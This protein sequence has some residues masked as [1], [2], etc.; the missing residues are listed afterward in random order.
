M[1]EK[2][3]ENQTVICPVGS[4]FMDLDK[5]FGKETEFF[6]HLTRSRIEFLKAIKSLIDEKI[7]SLEKKETKKGK[8][9]MTKIKVQ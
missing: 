7:D 3:N 9:K 6:E 1:T 2:K 8:K 5:S 4:F